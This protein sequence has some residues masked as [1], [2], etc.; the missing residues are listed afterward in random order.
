M[1]KKMKALTEFVQI[2]SKEDT[3]VSFH[4]SDSQIMTGNVISVGD[5]VKEVANGDQVIFDKYKAIEHSI[6][7]KKYYFLNYKTLICKL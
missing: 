1:K 3:N 4:V 2:E 5:E 7:G 6:E